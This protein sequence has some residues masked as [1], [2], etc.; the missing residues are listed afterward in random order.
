MWGIPRYALDIVKPIPMGEKAQEVVRS[1]LE[2]VSAQG[3][4][5]I[6]QIDL[7][8]RFVGELT[9]DEP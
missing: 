8:E 9:D 6:D 1:A 4:L 7:Y 3:K 2:A 5:G